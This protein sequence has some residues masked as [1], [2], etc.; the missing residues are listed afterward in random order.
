MD[1]NEARLLI[2]ERVQGLLDS[3]HDLRLTEH[4]G[5]CRDCTQDLKQLMKT[6][7][8]LSAA[9]IDGPPAGE[10][11]HIWKQIQ[12][13]QSATR[14]AIPEPAESEPPMTATAT[15]TTPVRR[16]PLRMAPPRKET[17]W[18]L[19]AAACLVACATLLLAFK[20]GQV[21]G[22]RSPETGLAYLEKSQQSASRYRG[23]AS[24]VDHVVAG[25]YNAVAPVD[26]TKPTGGKAD[27]YNYTETT[28]D[29]K[30]SESSVRNEYNRNKDVGG[31]LAPPAA[32]VTSFVFE[33][34]GK[35]SDAI[36]GKRIQEHLENT[37][38]NQQ[39]R[40][41][42]ERDPKKAQPPGEPETVDR[43]KI[44]KTGEITLEVKSFVEASRQADA[45]V[46]KYQGF[47]A[48]SRTFDQPGGTRS[49][50]IVIRVAPEKFEALFAE[51]KQGG[52]VLAERAGG[53]DI[54][55]QYV[56][57][58]AR[59]KNLQVAEGRLQDL[60]K[61]KSFMD[62]VESLLQVERELSR[63][64]GE[65]EAY[66]GQMRVWQNQ[67]SLSTIRL[68]IQEPA[69]AVPSGSLSV[70][71]GSLADAKKTLDAA[72]SNVGGQLLNGQ[73]SKREDGTLMGNYTLRAKFGRFAE[74]VGSIKG[75]GR[76]Q[77]ERIVNQP[78][79]GAVPDDARD[80]LCDLSLVL[81][82][83]SVQLPSGQLNLEVGGM[84]E[85]LVRLNTA[86]ATA[87]GSIV[88]NQT[89]R[90]PNGTTTSNIS[91]RVKAG[92]F[93]SLM[94]ALPALGRVAH[95]VVNGEAGQVQGGAAEVPCEVRLY[96]FEQAKEVPAGSMGLVVDKF[97]EGREQLSA[98]IKEHGIQ[99]L[100]SAS[101]QRPDESWTGSFTLGVKAEKMDAAVSAIEKL[102]RVKVREL[103]GL[104][105]GDLSKV[106]P[107]VIGQVTVVLEEKPNITPQEE[108][109]FRLLL[110]DTFGGFLTSMGY[111]IRGLGVILPWALILGVIVWFVV[112]VQRKKEAVAPAAE[113]AE[114]QA[115][116]S[117]A[118]EAPQASESKPEKK[119]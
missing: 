93:Q 58:E 8:L 113:A 112:R 16:P 43:P 9:R 12:A 20:V 103:K 5:A 40:Q 99:V 85:A 31:K 35:R 83:R 75:L 115:A 77:D 52:N 27:M 56:D 49:G 67:I 29:D 79:G 86:L 51:L 42:G 109:A 102:G 98:L 41:D 33:T 74:L 11:G 22:T 10:L 116:A 53:Q 44:I 65:I 63:V 107:N 32:P 18:K 25:Q 46:V 91:L 21:G 57:T 97:T 84:G 61:S 64:R 36:E 14:T 54:T 68:T 106:D 104:G 6:R 17:K 94:D 111:I 92:N 101:N 78:F 60:I 50:T 100:G 15:T 7:E 89:Q 19:V 119:A 81:F 73:T 4:L 62:K 95:R 110:R 66:Q 82:E 45:L 96:L 72:L 13:R 30:N 48:D 38:S 59:V 114:E 1:C 2:D 28:L 118:P 69:R 108:G 24:E 76:T 3:A 37:K 87:Q 70:E 90:Q 23:D 47:V 71:I 55:A 80:V 26:L 117:K 88:S 39:S 105:L 34:N